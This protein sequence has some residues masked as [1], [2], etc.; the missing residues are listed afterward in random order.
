M[1]LLGLPWHQGQDDRAKGV[2][3]VHAA[4][5]ELVRIGDYMVVDEEATCVWIGLWAIYVS[6]CDDFYIV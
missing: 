6:R 1:G 5:A 3:D 4:R 2:A